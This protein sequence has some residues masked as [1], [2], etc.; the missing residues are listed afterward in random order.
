[1]CTLFLLMQPIAPAEIWKGDSVEF[2]PTDEPGVPRT[3]LPSSS[4]S[5][6]EPIWKPPQLSTELRRNDNKR[7][8]PRQP[9][10]L[11]T[12]P[13]VRAAQPRVKEGAQTV[14]TTKA[15]PLLLTKSPKEP[16]TLMAPPWWSARRPS[17]TRL[18]V[19]RGIARDYTPFLLILQGM[20]LQLQG[21][22]LPSLLTL[23]GRSLTSGSPPP[24]G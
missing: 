11:S 15:L 17:V 22:A 2:S 24:P 8:I 19:K 9:I 18:P 21:I 7:F 13:T 23:Q 20:T 3:W 14:W 6:L 1:M 12:P 16:L 4:T 5:V 10:S